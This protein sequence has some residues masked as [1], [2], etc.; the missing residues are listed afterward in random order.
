MKPQKPHAC[1]S[2]ICLRWSR[3]TWLVMA[4]GMSPNQGAVCPNG[5]IS[6]RPLIGGRFA[7]QLSAGSPTQWLN[8][9][10]QYETLRTAAATTYTGT[11]AHQMGAQLYLYSVP[12]FR[13]GRLDLPCHDAQ[14]RKQHQ[15]PIGRARDV[16]GTRSHR[17]RSQQWGPGPFGH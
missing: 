6:R 5:T 12:E 16:S 10:G 17:A 13:P 14:D 1:G 9:G 4:S 11:L 7:L 3:P 8:N 2:K 15:Y